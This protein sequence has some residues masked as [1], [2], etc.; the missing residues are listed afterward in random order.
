MDDLDADDVAFHTHWT[1]EDRLRREWETAA[2]A[3]LAA[4][5]AAELGE[6]GA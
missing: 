2:A 3:E 4:V 6:A 1:G 5:D